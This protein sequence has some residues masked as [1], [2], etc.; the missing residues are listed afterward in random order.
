MKKKR[1]R[2][3]YVGS[4][5]ERN[6]EFRLMEWLRIYKYRSKHNKIRVE[7]YPETTNFIEVYGRGKYNWMQAISDSEVLFDEDY[8]T[9][10]TYIKSKTARRWLHRI[11]RR[12]KGT[13][14]CK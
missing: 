13:K 6:R 5:N 9:A 12:I 11:Y 8:Q 4:V 1:K 14:Y 10:L 3:V 2:I 7:V